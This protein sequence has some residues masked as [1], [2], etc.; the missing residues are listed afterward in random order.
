MIFTAVSA[1]ALKNILQ[2][3]R[4]SPTMQC[5]LHI[6]HRIFC[7]RWHRLHRREMCSQSRQKE[8]QLVCAA[9]LRVCRGKMKSM[10]FATY[11]SPKVQV[12]SLMVAYLL[13]MSV[14]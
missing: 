8:I 10:A 9:L 3:F 11:Y 13:T 6:L 14:R 5:F 2:H 4:F 1:A 7:V 12:G